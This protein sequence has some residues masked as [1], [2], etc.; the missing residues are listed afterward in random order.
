MYLEREKK[1][2]ELFLKTKNHHELKSFTKY[3]FSHSTCF[4]LVTIC[5][6]VQ[7][8]DEQEKRFTRQICVFCVHVLLEITL[9]DLW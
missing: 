1:V 9:Q 4:H 2:K 6:A 3:S 7:I 8:K 5:Q